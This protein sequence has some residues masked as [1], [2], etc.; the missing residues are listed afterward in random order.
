[1]FGLR[2]QRYCDSPAHTILIYVDFVLKASIS[3]VFHSTF[4]NFGYRPKFLDEPSETS[5]EFCVS[6]KKETSFLF[7]RSTFRNFAPDYLFRL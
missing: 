3:F 2:V 4:R 1:M 7:L 5:F 6:A